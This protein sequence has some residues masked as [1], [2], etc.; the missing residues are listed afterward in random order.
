MHSCYQDIP[1]KQ[2]DAESPGIAIYV[3]AIRKIPYIKIL[4]SIVQTQDPEII[5]SKELKELKFP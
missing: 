1:V 5:P 2:L 4:P 3:D